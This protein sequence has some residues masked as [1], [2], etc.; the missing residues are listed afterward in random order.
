MVDPFPIHFVSGGDLSAGMILD[1][2]DPAAN[3]YVALYNWEKQ[4]FL[5]VAAAEVTHAQHTDNLEQ[6]LELFRRQLPQRHPTTKARRSSRPL[7]A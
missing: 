2:A 4:A 6:Q 1:N 7:S 5:T 3:G